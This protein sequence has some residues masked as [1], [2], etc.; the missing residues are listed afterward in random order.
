MS[1]FHGDRL[2]DLILRNEI[3]LRWTSARFADQELMREHGVQI[4]YWAPF[5]EGRNG[6]F[7]NPLLTAI[8]TTHEKTV[9]QV[10]LRW[11]I[12]RGIVVI[13][14]TVRPERMA[15]NLGVFDFTLT[16]DEMARIATLDSGTSMFFDHRDPTMVTW[17]NSRA[18]A[19][20]ATQTPAP[21]GHRGVVTGTIATAA[22]HRTTTGE[23][24]M[25]TTRLATA[26]VPIGCAALVL[27]MVSAQ[28]DQ[29][30][31]AGG[32]DQASASAR[33]AAPAVPTPKRSRV[34]TA[35]MAPYWV[36]PPRL[37][38]AGQG[39]RRLVGKVFV[40]PYRQPGATHRVRRA[41]RDRLIFHAMVGR[42]KATPPR[43]HVAVPHLPDNQVLW[44]GR[45]RTRPAATG[46]TSVSAT[47][48]KRVSRRLAHRS[49]AGQRAAV[50]LSVTH[51]KDTYSGSPRWA[52]KQQNPATL[53][54]HPLTKRQYR[55]QVAAARVERLRAQGRQVV[56]KAG[57]GRARGDVHAQYS[58]WLADAGYYNT[59]EFNNFSPFAQAVNMNPNIECMAP[60][61]GTIPTQET[62][63]AGTTLSIVVQQFDTDGY[64]GWGSDS[65]ENAPGTQGGSWSGVGAAAAK[66]GEGFKRSMEILDT[67]EDDDADPDDGGL[68]IA[69]ATIGA[70]FVAM[71]TFEAYLFNS[72]TYTPYTCTSDDYP[73]L[74]TI[75]TSVVGFGNSAADAGTVSDAVAAGTI[76][77]PATWNGAANGVEAG[78][79]GIAAGW[80]ADNAAAWPTWA[81]D[82]LAPLAGTGTLAN[83]YFNG[84][85]AAYSVTPG[86]LPGD[87]FGG[88]ALFNGG[89]FQYLGPNPGPVGVPAT[90]EFTCDAVQKDGNCPETGT[91]Y[92]NLAFLTNPEFT[93]GLSVTNSEAPQV[94]V[95]GGLDLADP[96]QTV[97]IACTLPEAAP[98]GTLTLPFTGGS[99]TSLNVSAGSQGFAGLQTGYAVTFFGLD[100]EGNDVYSAD[101]TL[102]NLSLVPASQVTPTPWTAPGGTQ[103]STALMLNQTQPGQTVT[104]TL[105]LAD[106]QNMVE[107]EA[108]ASGGS[109]VASPDTPTS[110][111]C[112]VTPV[113][114]FGNTPITTGQSGGSEFLL[115]ADWP[116]PTG[117]QP[118]TGWPSGSFPQW[119]SSWYNWNTDFSDMEPVTNLNVGWTGTS[120]SDTAALQVAD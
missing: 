60:N 1:N 55:R 101:S 19:E 28:A 51:W 107:Y 43:A 50:A 53:A 88:G 110:L 75:G 105:T 96:T 37:V 54:K 119:D 14:K 34:R 86:T 3:T 33:R 114:F 103:T 44:R 117:S 8:A 40:E 52:L 104:A 41:A 99:P 78:N 83:Y 109:L 68:Y 73:P 112:S 42:T 115:G 113:A 84:G 18:E 21:G 38:A 118:S 81:Q 102:G 108:P 71:G 89:L 67:D 11:L 111:G 58:N 48:P 79:Q 69:M 97:S 25:R 57:S 116:M 49:F 56:A 95:A 13:P 87:P 6:L 15:E 2:V 85:M 77:D 22:S 16:E 66:S 76:P 5:A 12:Q 74:F 47:L 80:P 46:V 91:M 9:G 30:P 36:Q 7:S 63:Y 20:G 62:V 32:P 23:H 10:V 106:Y 45:T 98:Q 65:D 35:G 72:D 17:L 100:A 92:V 29:P 31:G 61:P 27:G 82:N 26:V 39:R 120:L 70:A 64:Y 93:S 90:T 4:E 59:V 24:G 94:Q